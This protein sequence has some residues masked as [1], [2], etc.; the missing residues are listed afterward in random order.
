MH[1]FVC[2]RC[3]AYVT[4]HS[5]EMCVQDNKKRAIAVTAHIRVLLN[6]SAIAIAA[7]ECAGRYGAAERAALRGCDRRLVVMIRQ[8][9]INMNRRWFATRFAK[10]R[11]APK[12]ENK[13]AATQP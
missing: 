2:V 12:H 10:T 13:S 6:A 5:W 9:E 3:S 1:V 8:H 7:S 4:V 11:D